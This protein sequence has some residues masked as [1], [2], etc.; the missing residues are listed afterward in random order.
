MIFTAGSTVE[1]GTEPTEND[2][3]S[4]VVIAKSDIT[5]VAAAVVPTDIGTPP[6]P[7]CK[8]NIRKVQFSNEHLIIMEDTV[9]EI[10]GNGMEEMSEERPS[11]IVCEFLFYL[12][13]F[14]S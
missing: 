6:P 2:T 8:T 12:I 3:E 11:F 9:H 1:N 10:N 5:T 4:I 13:F 14:F 7:K